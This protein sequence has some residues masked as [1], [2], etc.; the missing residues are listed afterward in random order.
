MTP[1]LTVIG[2]YGFIGGAIARTA[3]TDGVEVQSVYFRQPSDLRRRVAASLETRLVH[4]VAVSPHDVEDLSRALAAFSPSAVVAAVGSVSRRHTLGWRDHVDSNIGVLAEL[5]DAVAMAD[6]PAPPSLF[7]IGSQLEFGDAA[8]P[9]AED[10]VGMPRDAY[11]ASKLAGTTL[12]VA[13]RNAGIVRTTVVR[14]PLVFGPGQPPQMLIPQLIVAA[15]RGER[16]AMSEGTQLRRTIGSTN[17]A[18]L[19]LDLADR[20]MVE[21]LPPLLNL[22]AFD[23]MP[24]REIGSLV[25]RLVGNPSAS[26][27][28]GSLPMRVGEAMRQWPDDQLATQLGFRVDGDLETAMKET[29]DWYRS[30]LGLFS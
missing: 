2:G 20:S 29:I 25:L 27:D 16:V 3:V 11:G 22:P 8:M 24:I 12:A 6:L 13:A 15:L 1:R 4:R 14:A 5:I 9:W 28:F 30:N 19:V 18:R 10:T 26:L 23:E 7:V 21:D 17:L